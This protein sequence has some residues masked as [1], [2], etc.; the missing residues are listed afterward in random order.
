VVLTCCIL[1][2]HHTDRLPTTFCH[3]E[4]LLI[5]VTPPHIT[6][7]HL[8]A[9]GSRLQRLPHLRRAG[10]RTTPT[11]TRYAR[12]R[13]LPHSVAPYTCALPF[14]FCAAVFC[15]RLRFRVRAFVPVPYAVHCTTCADAAFF[16]PFCRALTVPLPSF[17]YTFTAPC[18]TGP[19]LPH[20]TYTLLSS[21]YHSTLPHPTTTQPPPH[22]STTYTVP[23]PP[24]HHHTTLPTHT[25]TP[26]TSHSFPFPHLFLWITA[27]TS[28]LYLPVYLPSFPT[29]FGN[30]YYSRYLDAIVTIVN[31][32]IVARTGA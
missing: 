12:P 14:P 9:T 7:T 28:H 2:L 20:Y 21:L 19:P 31:A 15:V 30:Q 8:P 16:A 27:H 22:C 32:R 10:L 23:S 25:H 5:P 4:P 1:V 13:A 29:H 11:V 18:P 17:L 6:T 26:F 24:S 3:R